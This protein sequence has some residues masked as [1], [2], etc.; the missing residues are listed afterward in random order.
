MCY[1]EAGYGYI[2]LNCK[3]RFDEVALQL[4]NAQRPLTNTKIL[5]TTDYNNI[6]AGQMS[7]SGT[8]LRMV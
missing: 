6:P 8:I 5:D 2:Y 4:S 1:G 7:Y 3:K